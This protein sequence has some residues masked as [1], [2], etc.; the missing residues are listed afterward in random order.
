MNDS[1]D[2]YQ[3][4]L[5]RPRSAG[6]RGE[7]LAILT[8]LAVW[9]ISVFGFQLWLSLSSLPFGKSFP[10]SFTFFNLPFHYW[11]T[12]QML[13]LLFIIICALFNLLIDRLSLRQSRKREGHN[14]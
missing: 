2:K 1:D 8:V 6:M 10:E 12:A 4:N 9:G 7:V 5:F 11:F 3:V 14:D 13:P